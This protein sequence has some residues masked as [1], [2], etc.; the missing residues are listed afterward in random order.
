VWLQEKI[1][2]EHS[3]GEGLPIIAESSVA[4]TLK[5]GYPDAW[6]IDSGFENLEGYTRKELA[7]KYSEHEWVILARKGDAPVVTVENL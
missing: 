3:K 1:R 7:E 5:D 4:K 2:G 6:F